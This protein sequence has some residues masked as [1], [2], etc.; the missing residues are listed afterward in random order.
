MFA[1]MAQS[2]RTER[3]IYYELSTEP[4]GAP[5]SR[6]IKSAIEN[7]IAAQASDGGDVTDWRYL[8]DLAALAADIEATFAQA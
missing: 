8:S 4:Y 2:V 3:S 5:M 1:G 6:E 7:V